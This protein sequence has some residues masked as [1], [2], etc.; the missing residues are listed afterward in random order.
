[1]KIRKLI[2]ALFICLFVLFS[3]NN[4]Y[5]SIKT[6]KSIDESVYDDKQID[7]VFKNVSLVLTGTYVIITLFIYLKYDKEDEIKEKKY[8][9]KI[10]YD[11]P[12]ELLQYIAKEKLENNSIL[13]SVLDLIKLGVYRVETFQSRTGKKT[14][15]FIYNE[16]NTVKHTRYQTELVKAIN[17]RLTLNQNNELEMDLLKFGDYHNNI[18]KRELEEYEK[19]IKLERNRLFGPTKKA[20]KW[21]KVLGYVLV[22]ITCFIIAYVGDFF[23]FKNVEYVALWMFFVGVFY[24]SM[25]VK[26]KNMTS[27]IIITIHATLMFLTGYYITG[28]HSGNLFIIPYLIACGLCIYAVKIRKHPK[29]EAQV[30]ADI[31]GLKRYLKDVDMKDIDGTLWDDYF[32]MAIA[33][34][35]HE[36]VVYKLYNYGVT[37]T[38]SLGYFVNQIGSY[39]DFCYYVYDPLFHFQE[40]ITL[41]ETGNKI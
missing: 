38:S 14:Y 36:D 4:S 7:R 32:I 39:E 12:P 1:M 21:V 35:L 18:L 26:T 23:S 16:K 19:K 6:V 27:L 40:Y 5:A 13:V 37:Q 20:P 22:A 15:K 33:L 11:L 28:N 10:P 8:C 9:E 29:I 30:K 3:F 2:I 41:N 31:K 24:P 25:I 34:G 17:K